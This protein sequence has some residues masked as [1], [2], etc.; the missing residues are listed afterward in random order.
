MTT[1]NNAATV[2]SQEETKLV[3]VRVAVAAEIKELLESVG[4]SYIKVGALLNEAR[5]DFEKQAEF[6]EW[7]N[8]EFGIKKA[9]TFKLMKVAKHFEED[10]R[11]SGVA[12]R[13]LLTLTD[14]MEDEEIMSKAAELAANGALD[15][16]A[17][18][19]LIDPPKQEKPASAPEIAPADGLQGVPAEHLGAIGDDSELPW[20]ADENTD[21]P[22]SAPVAAQGTH[23]VT[24]MVAPAN[25]KDADSERIAGLLSLLETLK[26]AN[27]EMAAELAAMRSERA[28][29]KA[30]APMLPHFK[31]KC[32]AVRLGLTEDEASKK[33]NVN[34]AKR[35][36]VKLGYG[37]GHEAW[38][39]I[40]EAVEA[41]T[42]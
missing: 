24:D 23:G 8:T 21:A 39:F 11:F 6:L 25:S 16:P 2:E 28:S 12:M 20:E 27:Q 26:L 13:V 40:S 9:Q 3:P 19:L 29:K 7:V 4:T 36:L 15:T 33:T 32:F 14:Y 30:T 5:P 1:V 22:Q 38:S 42:K 17:L 18:N 35:E 37:E 34:K 41:L 31:H 10:T